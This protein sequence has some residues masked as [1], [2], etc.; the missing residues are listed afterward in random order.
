VSKLQYVKGDAIKTAKYLASDDNWVIIPHIV[1][2]I[3]AW[4]SGFVMALSKE[5]GEPEKQFRNSSKKLGQCDY[6]NIHNDTSILI[7]VV[8]MYAQTGIRSISTGDRSKVTQKPIRYEHLV[9]CMTSIRD[10][11]SEADTVVAPKFGSLRA[12]GNWQFIE[13][14]I[15]EIWC[16]SFDVIVCEYP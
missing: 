3:K 2:D 11:L 9:S 10:S 7:T 1:N 5:W 16:P 12:G 8:N 13:E 14:L 4:G 15:E 6:I